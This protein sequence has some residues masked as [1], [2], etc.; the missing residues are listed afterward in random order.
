MPRPSELR[1][2]HRH[3][4]GA[5][6]GLAELLRGGADREEL[7]PLI[8]LVTDAQAELLRITRSPTPPKPAGPDAK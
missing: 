8:R 7:L 2:V 5:F 6:E 1:H 4:A 3:L